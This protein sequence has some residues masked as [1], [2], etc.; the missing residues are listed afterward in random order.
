VISR[1]TLAAFALEKRRKHAKNAAVIIF[2]NFIKFIF[3]SGRSG[4]KDINKVLQA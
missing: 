2:T 4:D 3:I 1:Y